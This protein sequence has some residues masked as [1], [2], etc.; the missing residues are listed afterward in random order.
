MDISMKEKAKVRELHNQIMAIADKYEMSMEELLDS[1]V[2]G[3]GPEMES[4]M[5]GE[6]EAPEMEAG[7]GP[8]RAKIAMI[9]GKMRRGEE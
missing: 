2:E 3:E 1:A 9:V 4:E 6:E 5:E 7:P 8:D